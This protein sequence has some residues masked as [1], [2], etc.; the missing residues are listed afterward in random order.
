VQKQG[1]HVK[2]IDLKH[3]YGVVRF[4]GNVQCRIREELVFQSDDA[5]ETMDHLE[6]ECLVNGTMHQHRIIFKDDKC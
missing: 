1:G 6:K 5:A 4:E 2:Q 3:N